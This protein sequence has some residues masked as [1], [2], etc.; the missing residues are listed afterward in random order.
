MRKDALWQIGM[1]T[2]GTFTDCIAVALSGEV[3]RAKVLSSSALRGMVREQTGERQFRISEQW[4][5]PPD[6][7]RGFVFQLLGAVHAPARVA[8]YDPDAG[9][10]TL[11]AAL[12]V[13][14]PPEGAAFE[15]RS[16]EEAPVLAARLA[17][18]TP[19]DAPLPSM[20]LRLAT[21]RGT[22]A[23]LTRGG[24]P[25]A[26]FVTEGFADLLVIGTQQR[27][28]LFA[29]DIVKP[30]PL[31][32]AVVEV[33]ERIGADGAILRPVDAG[34]V[35]RDAERLL[36]Q[37]ITVAAVALLHSYRCPDHEQEVAHLL[38]Q[39]GF[40]HVSCSA[41]LAP[42]LKILPRAQTAVV[43]A[44]LTPVIAGYVRGVRAGL[45]QSS[46]VHIMTSAGG[47]VRTEG[48]HPK[49]SLLSGPAGGIVG[50]AL[51]GRR[52]GFSR[53]IA[54]DMGGTSTDVARYDNDFEYVW[55]HQVG[56]AHLV[57][58]ALAIESVAAGGG[59]VCIA[60]RLGLRVGPESAG[61]SPGPACY[62]AG[63]PLT[64]TDV[65]LLLGRLASERFEIPVL[66]QASRAAAA[67]ALLRRETGEAPTQSGCDA[68]LEGFLEIANER[69]ADAIRAVS[70]R[71]GYDPAEYAL[72]AFGGAGGQ[73]ACA[74]A[75][76]LGIRH[77]L[78]PPDAGLLSAL[79]INHAV[80]ERFAER[81]ILQPLEAAGSQI[82]GWLAELETEA[83]AAVAE[84]GVSANEIGVRRRIVSLRFV[85]QESALTLEYD[86]TVPLADAFTR[87]YEAVFGH[88]PSS[89]A[90]EVES[91]RVV[92]S[93][94]PPADG[95]PAASN[96]N[97]PL[98]PARPS[99]TARARFS[100]QW[101]EVPTFDRSAL[102]P[103]DTLDGP[104]LVYEAHSTTVIE[105]GWTVTVDAAG[106]LIAAAIDRAAAEDD[107]GETALLPA[108]RLELFTHRF[109]AIAEEMG[110]QLRRNSISTN[111]KE[112]LDFSCAL[113]DAGGELIATAA[114]IPVHLGALGLCVRR[115]RE[116]LP[117]E[118]GDI[119]VTNQPAFGGSHL[120]DITVITPVFRECGELL[121]F[122]ASR[123]HHA[124]IGGTRP[125]SMPPRATSLWEEGVVLAPLYLRRAGQDHLET[126]RRLLTEGPYP[127]RNPADNIADLQAAVAA[128]RRGEQALLRL[129]GEHGAAV[130]REHM[131]ALKARAERLLTDALVRLPQGRRTTTEY[132]DDGS[133]LSVAIEI[134]DGRA[135]IDFAGT[136]MT[137]PGNLNATPAIAASAVLY[138][139]RLLVSEPLPLN[140]GLMRPITLRL[141]EG[142]L[143]N[144]DFT[145]EPCPAVVGGNTE[146]SQR[147]VDTLLRAL[148]IA[149]CSQGTMN[150]L[151]WG[152]E[153]FGYY[154]T[155]CG[156]AGATENAPG[157]GAVHTH[158]TNTRITDAEIIEHRYPVR[159]ER[160]AV[161][162]G[163]GGAGRHRGGDGVVREMTF[164]TPMTLSLLTQHRRE[165]P[166]GMA[167]GQAGTPGRQ[168]V[169]KGD[170]SGVI[171]LAASD[172]CE[173]AA[174]DRILLETPG[175]GG[176]GD[177]E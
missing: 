96:G 147:L 119:V 121:G 81:Q 50:A 112:R 158:M 124:E 19:A 15:A 17:T 104:A 79:G 7:A 11:T 127:S 37:G 172:G 116:T 146:V 54:F 18:R 36:A 142:S 29:L 14:L 21:T 35:T 122:V 28:D 51:A 125:G 155:V 26:F 89:R 120:P 110:E 32:A 126:V 25:T 100:G 85:G 20:A 84:E 1:D 77:V 46:A 78:V 109:T 66:P 111:V 56:D 43:D 5:A 61:A 165:G 53:L 62:G 140:E 103:G 176:W 157:A 163:S 3:R 48:F 64:V 40:R 59:S 52:S 156:G 94:R 132:L 129:A 161:R 6:F 167:G 174:G 168:R 108:V 115:V 173:V 16:P 131:D 63:G 22:N 27:P 30:A 13:A 135:V 68:L 39:A 47:L 60:D 57:A 44:Y 141:P 128:N 148:G 139:L 72:L 113:L 114:H 117:M 166:Y 151:L 92:A 101:R 162:P 98:R 171:E 73:H 69:M 123:A 150:N 118:P 10:I 65:N 97:A 159:V 175:G 9:I 33:A 23:L 49:D 149:A 144:P 67:D 133:P 160:F 145:C 143:L 74:V 58:P 80:I 99:G 106:A 38:R 170:G 164:L 86:S 82:P 169:L 137:H 88:R 83:R 42:F 154:E 102:A 93:S 70:L 87:R 177:A 107:T 130:V 90:V 75:A 2:G 55:E 45:T 4:N 152:T 31:Y 153:T 8:R 136:A 34:Q 76:R 71:R 41:D 134:A 91:L 138:V 24:A 12:N 95:E 105:S